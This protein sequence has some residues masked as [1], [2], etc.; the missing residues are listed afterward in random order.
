MAHPRCDGR[1]AGIGREAASSGMD[2]AEW[3]HLS[4]ENNSDIDTNS[5]SSDE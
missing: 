3:Y 4:D 2:L 5:G 1:H